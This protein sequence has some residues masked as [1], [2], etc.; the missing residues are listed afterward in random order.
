[1]DSN[2][3]SV[4]A[5]SITPTLYPANLKPLQSEA[6]LTRRSE[7]TA[8]FGWG[9]WL[10]VMAL[11]LGIAVWLLPQFLFGCGG[12]AKEFE[13]RMMVGAM[14]R[15]QQ[16]F[17]LEHN[18]FSGSFEA[19]G[20]G[21]QATTEHY[22]YASIVKGDRVFNYAVAQGDVS[23][24]YIGAVFLMESVIQG[25]GAEEITIE[26]ATITCAVD[27]QN[28]DTSINLDTVL[29]FLENNIP[30]CHPE[31]TLMMRS[32]QPPEIPQAVITN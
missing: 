11:G 19:L 23:Q 30:H 24:S 4:N 15:G 25:I 26:F 32:P 10:A 5:Q 20:L 31:T 1:M 21:A 28:N 17:F 13:G 2:L 3:P 14:G 16:A 22:A 18:R 7:Q 27:I 29:P 12:R 8:L 9:F 6:L